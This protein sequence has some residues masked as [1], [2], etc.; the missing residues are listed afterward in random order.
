MFH[1]YC[2]DER[3]RQ[4]KNVS[5]TKDPMDLIFIPRKIRTNLSLSCSSIQSVNYEEEQNPQENDQNSQLDNITSSVD[6]V[7]CSNIISSRSGL[8]K[9]NPETHIN[10]S[11][12]QL[13]N[14]IHNKDYNAPLRSSKLS[15]NKHI[16]SIT[17]SINYGIYIY[18]YTSTYIYYYRKQ[19]HFT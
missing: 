17:G 14:K 13:I 6:S 1:R 3:A 15:Q 19:Q 16:N 2:F 10:N 8:S 4:Y 18:I 7:D 5:N 9:S 11:G 12:T